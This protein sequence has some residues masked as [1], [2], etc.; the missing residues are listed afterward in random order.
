LTGA[1]LAVA[2]DKPK[3][4]KAVSKPLSQASEAITKRKNCQEA[5]GKIREAEGAAGRT[6]YDNFMIADMSAYCYVQLKQYGDAATAYEAT[7]G[8]QYRDAR[9][10]ARIGRSI[11]S[12]YAQV[13]NYPKMVEA[14][15]RAIRSGWA[16]DDTY[17][18]VAQGLYLINDHKGAVAFIE[19][20]AGDLAKRGSVP[21]ENL[22]KFMLQSC[23]KLED[24]ACATRALEHM[25]QS[26]P[27]PEY[28][29]NLMI[30][31]N[32]MG[33]SDRV[34]LQ[35]YRLAAE[36]NGIPRA[37]WYTEMAQLALEQGLPGEA[38]STMEKA[39]ERKVFTDQ[40]D[41]D[42]NSRLL[43]SARKQAATDKA[44]IMRDVGKARPTSDADVRQGEALASYGQYSQAISAIERG[45]SRGGI[46]S[47]QDAKLSLG[48]A[49]FRAGMKAEA[50]NTFA[51]IKGDEAFERL[52]KLW[53]LH[54]R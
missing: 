48:I 6:E 44:I 47:L 21:S 11:A 38:Q 15:K 52:G 20:Y 37:S 9:D 18:L 4:S 31:L 23:T 12:M 17:S 51:S 45:L 7:L 24:D 30:S 14:G 22:Y 29:Q 16:D 41:I 49:Q 27:K 1:S 50:V 33:G 26:Y 35:M 25:V 28:W 5:L 43:E 19:N 46:K 32:R 54:A 13:R 53:A 8:S 42:R 36:V 34:V 3:V 39:F 2:Q 10:A 40:R